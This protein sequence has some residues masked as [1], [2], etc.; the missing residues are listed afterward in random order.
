MRKVLVA[1]IAVLIGIPGLVAADEKTRRVADLEKQ[2]AEMSRVLES[3]QEE[4]AVLMQEEAQSA[5]T[6]SSAAS[7][8]GGHWTDRITLNGQVRF[9]GYDM[10]NMWNYDSDQDWDS[11]NAFR[12]KGTL[13]ATVAVTNDVTAVL[14]LTNQTWG[15][16]VTDKYGQELDNTGN[17]FFLDNAYVN[18]RNM[19]DLPVDLTLGRQ[20]LIYGGGFVLFD[21]NPQF[22]SS[23]QYFDGVK[24]T[25]HLG[26]DV[27]LDA[28]YMQDEENNRDN[29]SNDDINL[30]GFYLTA[31]NAPVVG[32]SELYL[33]NRNDETL[34]KDIWML[35]ARVSDKL[36]NGIDYAF[37]AAYQMG[38]ALEG[39]DQEAMGA[40]FDVGY[41]FR[42]AA[43]KPRL[44]GGFAFLGGDDL[45]TEENEGWDVFYGGW[46]GLFGDLMGWTYVNLPGNM[47]VLNTI[48]DHD[49][50]S[51]TSLEAPFS[52][53]RM[54][55]LGVQ[56]DL[57]KNL[58]GEVSW[59][60]L[61]FNETYAG[62]DDDFGDYY[63]AALTYLYNKQLS[64]SLC[65][66]MIAP[67]EAFNHTGQDDAT[68]FYWETDY[69]F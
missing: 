63:Q 42:S 19:F 64:F 38:D 41:T 62:I 2:I 15:N 8:A 68:E 16:G 49:K 61:T 10:E 26:S 33:L 46:G 4:V 3:L 9:R 28:F 23:S 51:S 50:L 22:A 20:N 57:M 7:P 65:G 27:K 17:K 52:N 39:V 25:W 58:S 44:F 36:G 53:F 69:K 14:Q 43:M 56:A 5:A 67:G 59:S 11:W 35:G 48:Y 12:A 29:L 6:G 32:K 66:S 24:L 31:A 37:E 1:V 54:V 21:G 34:G 55:S 60:M 30:T 40:K 45:D 47:N 18:V 13:K